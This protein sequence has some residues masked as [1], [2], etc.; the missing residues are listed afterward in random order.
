MASKRYGDLTRQELYG[1]AQEREIDGREALVDE[2]LEEHHAAE[3][4]LNEID[5]MGPDSTR[6]GGAMVTAW[7]PAPTRVHPHAPTTPPGNL[8]ATV[9]AT[10]I[11]LTVGA[12]WSVGRPVP[13]R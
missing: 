11:D 1:R 2:S 5:R 7:K 8:I 12:A 3:L 4:L 6:L 13:R 10:V 9:P